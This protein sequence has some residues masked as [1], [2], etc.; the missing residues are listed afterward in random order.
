MRIIF[1]TLALSARVYSG[2][3]GVSV[4]EVVERLSGLPVD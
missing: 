3:N 1:I 4:R 2:V